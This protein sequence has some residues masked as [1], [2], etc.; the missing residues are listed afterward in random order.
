MLY[1]SFSRALLLSILV[2]KL[3]ALLALLA[4]LHALY[5]RRRKYSVTNSAPFRHEYRLLK[6]RKSTVYVS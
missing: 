3:L 6:A 1:L 4:A 2:L 5:S